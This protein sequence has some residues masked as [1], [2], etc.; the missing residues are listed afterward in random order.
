[1]KKYKL[2]PEEY[3]EILKCIALTDLSL[4]K[5]SSVHDDENMTGSLEIDIQDKK[6][7]VDSGKQV[8]FYCNL[9]FSAKGEGKDKVGVKITAKYKIEYSKTEEVPIQ[10]EFTDIFYD[11]SLQ[12]IVWPFFREHVQSMLARMN[13]PPLTLPMRRL[14]T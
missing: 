9:S 13:L 2:T 4:I 10:K 8:V 5:S 6:E 1:M 14:Y 7:L 3:Q 12:F 11:Q